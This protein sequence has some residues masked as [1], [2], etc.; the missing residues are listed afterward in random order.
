VNFTQWA[1]K[2]APAQSESPYAYANRAFNAGVR[3]APQAECAPR[4]ASV[5]D[6]AIYQAIADNFA[7]DR[8][9][10]E[11]DAA[12]SDAEVEAGW[13][14]TFS[15]ENPYCPCNLKSFT[16]AVRW[17]ERAILAANKGKP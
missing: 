3:A 12:L 4:V 10:A 15:T 1:E 11:K 6:Q 14:K 17:A 16:K 7:R 13:R 5:E 8:A 2:N 9:D